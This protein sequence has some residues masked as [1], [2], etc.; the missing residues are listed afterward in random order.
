MLGAGTSVMVSGA[1]ESSKGDQTA[2]APTGVDGPRQVVTEPPPL[3][4]FN[5]WI[6]DLGKFWVP[7]WDD[8][9]K[10]DEGAAEVTDPRWPAFAACM[11]DRGHADIRG[12][13]GDFRQ[14]DMD[15]LL[16]ELNEDY[17]DGVSNKRR[18]VED[19]TGRA[20]D[21]LICADA[22][23]ARPVAAAE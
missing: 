18:P 23:L 13:D 21:F 9:H 16:A 15:R 14:P 12:D 2:G 3:P 6:D 19:F 11:E 17:P 7:A 8:R 22:E 20:A 4:A 5:P 10:T 1:F